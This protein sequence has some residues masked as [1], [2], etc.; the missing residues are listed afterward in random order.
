MVADIGAGDGRFSVAVARRVGPEGHVYATEIDPESL[1][2]IRE[3]V[4]EAGLENVTV[5]AAGFEL[6]GIARDWPTGWFTSLYCAA[7]RKPA[8][9]ARPGPP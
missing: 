7:F 2:R 4:R 9:V 5:L 3:S 6:V 8:P 1:E